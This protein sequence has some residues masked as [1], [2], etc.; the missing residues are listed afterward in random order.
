LQRGCDLLVRQVL[1]KH[2]KQQDNLTVIALKHSS[3]TRKPFAQGRSHLRLL[4]LAGLILVLLFAGAGYWYEKHLAGMGQAQEPAQPTSGST[5]STSPSGNAT[6]AKQEQSPPAV[7]EVEK[8]KHA[9]TA[10]AAKPVG[11]KTQAPKPQTQDSTDRE[12][13]AGGT[14]PAVP[15]GAQE[16]AP[17]QSAPPDG[18]VP[19]VSQPDS[20]EQKAPPPSPPAASDGKTPPSGQAAGSTPQKQPPPPPPAPDTKPDAPP[21]RTLGRAFGSAPRSGTNDDLCVHG[22]SWALGIK[23]GERTCRS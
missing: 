1:A 13:D 9:F 11:E 5:P 18:A 22:R 2:R 23:D 7:K 6:N 20:L 15:G 12:T 19:T 8:V 21:N 3:R 16:T 10:K 4:V 17:E 14:P